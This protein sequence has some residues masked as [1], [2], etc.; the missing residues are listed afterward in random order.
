MRGRR[1]RGRPGTDN[2]DGTVS[3]TALSEPF[4]WPE[5]LCWSLSEPLSLIVTYGWLASPCTAASTSPSLSREN[6]QE[7]GLEEEEEEE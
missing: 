2:G 3:A 7:Q 6:A 5:P 4:S 1:G